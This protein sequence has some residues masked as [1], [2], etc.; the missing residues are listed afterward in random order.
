MTIKRRA[1][2]LLSMEF[3]TEIALKYLRYFQV[4]TFIYVDKKYLV[5]ESI[6]IVKIH[7][8]RFSTEIH[9]LNF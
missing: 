9:I 6:E 8:F 3:E 5:T 7:E 4:F 1:P 2:T